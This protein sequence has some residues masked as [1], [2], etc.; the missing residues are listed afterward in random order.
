LRCL[1]GD[2][3]V[4]GDATSSNLDFF[5]DDNVGPRLRPLPESLSN[6]LIGVPEA[7]AVDFRGTAVGG[8]QGRD[9]PIWLGWAS[10]GGYSWERVSGSGLSFSVCDGG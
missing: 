2:E 7:G 8:G 4:P 6:Y 5:Y 1:S 10:R 9:G 3:D